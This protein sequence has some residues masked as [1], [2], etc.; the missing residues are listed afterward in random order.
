MAAY[1]SADKIRQLLLVCFVQEK[2]LWK[3]LCVCCTGFLA[4]QLLLDCFLVKPTGSSFQ[5]LPLAAE[6]IPDILVCREIGFD[7]RKLR[8]YGYTKVSEYYDGMDISGKFVGWSG[9]ENYEPLRNLN[10]F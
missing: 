8:K 2:Y 10:N 6:N 4:L 5:Q 9:M 1:R 7:P 3:L